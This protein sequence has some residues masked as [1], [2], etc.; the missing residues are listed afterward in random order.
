MLIDPL[1]EKGIENKYR[2]ALKRLILLDYDGTLVEYKPKP[3]QALPSE[4]VLKVLRKLSEDKGNRLLIVTG[5]DH[6]DVDSLLGMLDIEI[7][8]A[9]GAIQKENGTWVCQVS[10]DTT[11][12]ALIRPLMEQ[13]GLSCPESFIEDKHF[14][15]AWHYRTAN[16]AEGLLQS[17]KLVEMLAPLTEKNCLKILDGN[18]VVEVMHREIGKGQAVKRVIDSDDYDFILSVGDDVTDEEIF[19]LLAS[20]SRAYTIKVGEGES[21]AACR[22]NSAGEVV[23][24]L[25]NLTG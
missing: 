13:A 15:L 8:A 21:A 22:I 6:P 3:A 19:R 14:S 4:V 25:N 16:S 24:F 11:W 23:S 2:S 5:R 12:K 1:Q 18:K 10:E 7:I 17:R 9:H 20:D